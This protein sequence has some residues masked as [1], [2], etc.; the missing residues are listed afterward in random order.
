[1]YSKPILRY[2][3]WMAI[4]KTIALL[5]DTH[6]GMRNDSLDFHHLYEKFYTNVFFPKLKENGIK[7]IVQVG[8]LFDRRKY[9]N[10]NTLALCRRILLRQ[11]G[12]IQYAHGG[13]CRQP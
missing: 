2:D 4:R 5:G 12:R 13:P 1:M 3:G 9:I 7:T 11:A 10:F 8:D 6:F